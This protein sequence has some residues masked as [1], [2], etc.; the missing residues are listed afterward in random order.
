MSDVS[1]TPCRHFQSGG[2]LECADIYIEKACEVSVA[3]DEK[4]NFRRAEIVN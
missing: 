4:C 1:V 2:N 3:C